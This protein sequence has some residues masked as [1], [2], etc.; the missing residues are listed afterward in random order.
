MLREQAKIVSQD[1]E[2]IL[3]EYEARGTL[4][5]GYADFWMDLKDLQ[6][7]SKLTIHRASNLLF[8]L[9]ARKQLSVAF[10]SYPWQELKRA[11]ARSHLANPQLLRQ[12]VLLS[13]YLLVKPYFHALATAR[14]D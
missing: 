1:M 7:G 11:R 8:R 2:A 3:D 13:L 14:T 4:A 9:Q 5:N 12:A 6:R 10:S